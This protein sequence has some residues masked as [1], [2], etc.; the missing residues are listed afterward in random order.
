MIFVQSLSN[1]QDH[2]VSAPHI[3]EQNASINFY[4]TL[5]L[6]KPI[7]MK[8]NSTNFRICFYGCKACGLQIY[9]SKHHD[10]PD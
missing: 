8:E 5:T 1:W 10:P 3:L 2:I 9:S 6:K 7:I 4:F